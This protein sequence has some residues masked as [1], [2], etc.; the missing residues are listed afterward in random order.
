MQAPEN[1][2]QAPPD[3]QAECDTRGA[4]K[5]L[6]STG[7]PPAGTACK[8]AV[9]SG[10]RSAQRTGQRPSSRDT[11]LAKNVAAV[12]RKWSGDTARQRSPQRRAAYPARAGGRARDVTAYMKT[13]SGEASNFSLLHV[14]PQPPVAF[15]ILPVGKCGIPYSFNSRWKRYKPYLHGRCPALLPIP[16]RAHR[17]PF[18]QIRRYGK[19]EE[20]RAYLMHGDVKSIAIRAGLRMEDIAGLH[21]KFAAVALLMEAQDDILHRIHLRIRMPGSSSLYRAQPVDATLVR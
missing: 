17:T 18:F 14:T 2:G 10:T 12:H 13:G 5:T 15:W 3:R 6:G 20:A 21:A 7:A 9:R 11:S 16:E 19:A 8:A 4:D 1:T